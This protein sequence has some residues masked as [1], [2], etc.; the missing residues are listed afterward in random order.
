V[1]GW[2]RLGSQQAKMTLLHT[3][4]AQKYPKIT[5]EFWHISMPGLT[6]SDNIDYLFFKKNS[7][8]IKSGKFLRFF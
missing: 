8:V 3:N 2:E 7:Y 5:Q 6:I 4:L 1:V